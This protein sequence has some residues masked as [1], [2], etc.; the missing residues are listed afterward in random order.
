MPLEQAGEHH[1]GAAGLEAGDDV[2]NNRLHCTA[3]APTWGMA[4]NGNAGSLDFLEDR[5]DVGHVARERAEALLDA[6]LVANVGINTVED[7]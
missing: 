4:G 3:T 6:L 2:G 1:F 7:A 5:D